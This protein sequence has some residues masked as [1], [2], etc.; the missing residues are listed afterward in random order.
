M[1]DEPVSP[2][3]DDLLGPVVESFLARFRRG[4]RPALTEL[5]ALHPDL[6]GEI[7]ALIPALVKL[8]QLGDPTSGIGDAPSDR[9]GSRHTHDEGQSPKTF[10]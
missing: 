6:A 1:N 8:E 9:M 3:D 7:H 5:I 2:L 10:G 4:E